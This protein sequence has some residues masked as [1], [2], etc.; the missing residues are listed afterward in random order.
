MREDRDENQVDIAQTMT[1]LG[2]LLTRPIKFG[3]LVGR[4]FDRD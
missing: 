4:D 1:G 2:I 3:S